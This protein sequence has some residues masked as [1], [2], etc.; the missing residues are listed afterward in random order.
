MK[1]ARFFMLATLL[2]LGCGGCHRSS[3][4]LDTPDGG[5]SDG[6]SDADV[7]SD[8]DADTDSPP[9]DSDGDWLSDSFEDQ[10]GTDP[11][12]EDTD[13]DGASDFIEWIAGTDPNDPDSNPHAEGD[14]FFLMPHE[15]DPIPLQDTF[16]FSTNI[17]R[18]DVFILMDTTGSMGGAINNLKTDLSSMIIPEVEAIIPDVWFGVGGF[19]DYP[20]SPY[21]SSGDLPLYLVQRTTDSPSQA[22]AA[23]NELFTN[24]GGDTPESQV[25]ALWATATGSGLGDYVPAQTECEVDEVG[26]PCFR[27]WA[28][29]IILLVT[30]AP[31]HN[32]YG[33]Y[34]PYENLDPEPP[35]WGDAAVALNEIHAKVLGIWVDSVADQFPVEEHCAQMAWDTNATTAENDPVIFAVDSSGSGLGDSVVEAVEMFASAVPIERVEAV[36]RDDNSDSVDAVEAFLERIVPNTV[37]GVEDALNPGV[38]C[39]GGLETIDD[40]DDEVPDAFADLLPGTPVC[41][42]I[43][44][45][46][47]Q[48]IPSDDVPQVFNMFVDVVGDE[49]TVLDTRDVF[50]VV[51]PTDPI[52]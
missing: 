38:F 10:L 5:S 43:V 30:D 26:Y 46:I 33:D 9:S 37:G 49:V 28:V 17:I 44:P 14:F 12:N 48:S 15:Q 7:D 39:V 40:D 21:G 11:D 41:F 51:P 22:Q 45:K 2:A 52:D 1:I 27:P 47:N 8:T 35:E 42:D 6:D 13:G 3:V 32:A 4:T 29:P 31:F 36:G 18:A 20:Q 19:D 50:F 25:P 23:V 34:E 16:V 24:S